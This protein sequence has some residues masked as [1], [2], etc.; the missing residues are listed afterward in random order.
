MFNKL[1]VTS[2]LVACLAGASI[3]TGTAQAAETP[4]GKP[5][6]YAGMEVG[7]VYLQPV[8]MMP[9]GMMRPVA[10]SDIHLEA[11]IHATNNNVNGFKEGE[12]IPYL[13]I[14]YEIT[15]EGSKQVLKGDLMAMTANDGPHYGENVKLMGPGKYH[16]K[17]TILPP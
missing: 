14:T 15:K 11:D 13:G 9:A 5:I 2:A 10:K 17:F 7:A 8:P 16:L 6:I 12:W 4:I 1:K 3:L